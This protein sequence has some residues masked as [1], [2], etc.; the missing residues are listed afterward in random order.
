VSSKYAYRTLLVL[1]DWLTAAIAWGA[2]YYERK[3]LIEHSEFKPTVTFWIGIFLVPI[4]WVLL[5]LI[6]GVYFDVRRLYRIEVISKTLKSS[7]I[8]VVLLFFLLILDDEV[9]IYQTYYKS[10]F[11]LFLIHFGL[12]LIVRYVIVSIIV[13]KVQSN[14]LT[15]KT[16]LIGGGEKG[17]NIYNEVTGLKKGIGN[18]FVGY[19]CDSS[20]SHASK[21]LEYLGSFDEIERVI[22]EHQIEEVIVAIDYS[23]KAFLTKLL[24]KVERKNVRV[25]VPAEIYDILLGSVKM[26]NIFGA[27]LFEISNDPMTIGHQIFKRFLDVVISIVAL[28]VLLPLYIVLAILVK[29]S[30]EGPI[31]FL[32]ERIGKN[33]KV[34]KIIKYRTMFVDAEKMGPQLS[35][36]KDPRIT[37]LG[38]FMRK[39]RLDE[40]PQFINVIKGDMSL[41]GPRPE[42]QFYID[43]IAELEPQFLQLT[44]VRPGITSWG[45]VK[46]GYA[47]NVEQMIQRMKFDL[48]YLNNR[49][50]TLDFKIMLHTILII[51]KAKGK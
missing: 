5:Y 1:V 7:L 34:F 6:Q 45:Q 26:D 18:Q 32:Q 38:R 24:A 35:S 14:Q 8:G 33:G 27:L 40:F 31:F 29:I 22:E 11:L 4:F 42:R 12:T 44:K 15:Y 10:I 51:F 30:S 50:L 46:F 47:E 19:V 36:E 37:R 17:L 21:V 41:V 9:T 49:S 39:L 23:D 13:N 48:L 3:N 16:L 25:K 43:K 20:T 2:F 28:V